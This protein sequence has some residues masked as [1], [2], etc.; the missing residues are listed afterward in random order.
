MFSSLVQRFFSFPPFFPV[1]EKKFHHISRQQSYTTWISVG[2]SPKNVEFAFGNFFLHCIE[3][4]I[5]EVKINVSQAPLKY[6]TLL[7]LGSNEC[8]D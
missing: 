6:L 7:I 1:C 3:F 2:F 8:W 5:N 4:L